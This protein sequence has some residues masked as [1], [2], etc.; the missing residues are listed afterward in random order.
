MSKNPTKPQKTKKSRNWQKQKGNVIPK[1]A[2]N[3]TDVFPKRT[4]QRQE[5]EIPKTH[6][7]PGLPPWPTHSA[8]WGPSFLCPA[9]AWGHFQRH[10]WGPWQPGFY[11][12]GLMSGHTPPAMLSPGTVSGLLPLPSFGKSLSMPLSWT[13]ILAPPVLTGSPSSV[14]SCIPSTPRSWHTANVLSKIWVGESG[15]G[16]FTDREAWASD[17]VRHQDVTRDPVWGMGVGRTSWNPRE[18]TS[19]TR[20]GGTPK[21]ERGR[22]QWSWCQSG[23]GGLLDFSIYCL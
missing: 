7:I 18:E 10:F 22:Q 2:K 6:L 8:L 9:W 4:S 3:R 1:W 23:E 15:K 12:Y 16:T 17:F 19:V 13:F 5:L 14:P 11:P 21:M 20:S